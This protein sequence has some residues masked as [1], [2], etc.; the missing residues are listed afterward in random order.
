MT[1]YHKKE[2]ILQ[3]KEEFYFEGDITGLEFI[4][5]ANS[6]EFLIS[7]DDQIKFQLRI[8]IQN[9]NRKSTRFG[10]NLL[11]PPQYDGPIFPVK[12]STIGE[13]TA[14]LA[15]DNTGSAPFWVYS[16]SGSNNTLVMSSSNINEAYGGNFYQGPIPYVP[17]PSEYFDSGTEP[18][19]TQFPK[20][21]SPI[22]FFPGDEI[23]FGNNENYT[24][25]IQSVTSPQNNIEPD[26]KGKIKIVLDS[27]V[28]E[29]I[30]KDFFLIRRYVP[31]AS[32]FIINAPFPYS[33]ESS[34]SEANGIIL[35]TYPTEYIKN[36]GSL[37]VTDLISKGVIK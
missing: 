30:N 18:S 14:L 7:D 36:S 13:R 26:E 37:I 22:E 11:F 9:P 5:K 32:S 12:I 28:P 15:G 10:A 3:V 25:T 8:E 20:I 24:Y 29:S 27:E 17:G 1:F 19:G 2:Y 16:G 23:R 31:K 34:G 33:A 4:I 35:P 21:T 6:G